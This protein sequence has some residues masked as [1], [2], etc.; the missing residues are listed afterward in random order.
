MTVSSDIQLW[1]LSGSA[2]SA[3]TSALMTDRLNHGLAEL[4][5]GDRAVWGV[6]PI[7]AA[8]CAACLIRT[9]FSKC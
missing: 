7:Q 3:A 2:V 4:D 6:L 5:T 8:A 9:L 1:G